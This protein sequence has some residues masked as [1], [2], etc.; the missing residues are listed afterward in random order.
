MQCGQGLSI[1]PESPSGVLGRSESLVGHGVG[2]G[3]PCRSIDPAKMGGRCIRGLRIPVTT[4]LGQLG[5][6][7]AQEKILAER[8]ARVLQAAGHAAVHVRALGMCR[9]TDTEIFDKAAVAVPLVRAG[10]T[11]HAGAGCSLALVYR[12]ENG[13]LWDAKTPRSSILT[14]KTLIFFKKVAFHATTSMS[15][16]LGGRQ[17]PVA[18]SR[19]PAADLPP[20]CRRPL[21]RRLRPSS[22]TNNG[23]PLGAEGLPSLGC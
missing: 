7:R 21:S 10:A 23:P 22:C 6:G 19:R 20:T 4:V 2:T 8:V 18:G 11:S 5:A 16:P 12:T 1:G 15:F 3:F 9:A 13:K 17:Q 14:D